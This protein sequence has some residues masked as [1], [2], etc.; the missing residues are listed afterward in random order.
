VHGLAIDELGLHG[1][2]L[3]GIALEARVPRARGARLIAL[4]LRLTGLAL[5]ALR[6]A[7][8][9]RR[10]AEARLE[11]ARERLGRAEAHRER[12][13][14]HRQL[15][16]RDEAQRAELEAEIKRAEGK[17]GNEGFVAKAPEAVVAG[18]RDKLARLREERDAL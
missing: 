18:E 8:G 3:R 12:D 10:L 14:Q 15:G 6:V 2:L 16:L 13:V 11:G 4:A 5:R 1:S 9:R 7:P 17:L